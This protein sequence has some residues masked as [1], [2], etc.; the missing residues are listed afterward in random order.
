M[1]FEYFYDENI[2]TCQKYLKINPPYY[3]LW[4]YSQNMFCAVYV[5]L[6]YW[7]AGFLLI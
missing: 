5:I 3:R 6:N 7:D 2:R 4:E 1:Y